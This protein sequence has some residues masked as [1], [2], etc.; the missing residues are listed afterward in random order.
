MQALKTPLAQG[1]GLLK[2]GLASG[3]GASR[4]LGV[5]YKTLWHLVGA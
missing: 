3:G 5:G 1:L 4:V 2:E